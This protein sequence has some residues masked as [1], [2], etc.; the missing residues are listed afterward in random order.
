MHSWKFQNPR[1]L[2]RLSQN[3]CAGS[4]TVPEPTLFTNLLSSLCCIHVIGRLTESDLN[5]LA[6]TSLVNNAVCQLFK[7]I[8]NELS[9]IEIDKCKNVGL[10]SVMKSWT[11]FNPSQKIFLENAGWLRQG[12]VQ[13]K[14]P[15]L[16]TFLK[17]RGI[18]KQF[19]LKN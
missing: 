19:I 11:S 5:V 4:R 12:T 8:R 6:R 9:A 18:I 3:P 15:V 7:R 10:T 1:W 16:P 2:L 17:P 13:M 14:V